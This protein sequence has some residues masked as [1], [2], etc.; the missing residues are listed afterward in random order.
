MFLTGLAGAARREALR[1]S[2]RT[3]AVTDSRWLGGRSLED[4]VAMALEGGATFVQLREK[5]ADPARRAELARALLAMCRVRG[6]PFVVDDDVECALQ[7]GADGVHVG[8]SDMAC[9]KARA[10]LGPDAIVGVSAKDVDEATAAQRAG[11]DY[12]GVGAVFP[13]STKLDATLP[14]IDGVA[15]ACDAVDVSVVGIGGIDAG[16]V[17]LLA[18]TGVAGVAVVS[19][20]FASSDP[21]EAAAGIDRAA[22]ACG[23]GLHGVPARRCPASTCVL[24]VAGSDSSG[25]AGI[26]ADLKTFAAHL[27]YGQS[28]VCA[29]TAQNT[30]GV[31]G[32]VPT[33]P[34]S[35]S[36][37]LRAVFSDMPPAATKVGMVGTADA[38]R[39]LADGLR[40]FEAR[41]VVVD[42]VM[43]ST[44]GSRLAQDDAVKALRDQVLP[45]ASVVTPNIPEAQALSGMDGLA[46]EGLAAMAQ[47]AEKIAAL[48]PGAV[49]VKGGHSDAP[50]ADVLRL[51]DGEVLVLEGR[52]VDTADTHGTGCTLSSAIACG[53]ACGLD[54][55]SAV[56]AAKEYLSDCLGAGLR[57][58]AGHGPMDH[59]ARMRPGFVYGDACRVFPWGAR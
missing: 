7:V 6:V 2:L 48:T 53:L 27:L 42:P 31:T 11:A 25:G 51:P 23:L 22:R 24:T 13:T 32:V 20:I 26:Q 38:A 34:E 47:A 59:M 49:L 36:L 8:Q 1:A 43:V 45:L 4:A 44:S 41:N 18:G 19:A 56:A 35:V 55:V 54:V 29:L 9:E 30:L 17:G 12:L 33:P 28:L 3:Y 39:A 57:L 10:V 16:N 58:G 21:R 50:A 5:D 15:R 14:G 46:R 40:S 37:Q 52:R